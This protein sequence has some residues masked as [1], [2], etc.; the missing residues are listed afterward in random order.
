MSA[1]IRLFQ[2][3]VLFIYSNLTNYLNYTVL[4]CA[5]YAWFMD[6]G[7]GFAADRSI[8]CVTLSIAYIHTEILQGE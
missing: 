4:F 7:L 2:L 6:K 5:V 3:E 1:P 8:F